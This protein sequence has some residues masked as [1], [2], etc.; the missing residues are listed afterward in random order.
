[1]LDLM[2]P[3]HMIQ[4]RSKSKGALYMVHNLILG[5][6]IVLR[7]WNLLLR[8]KSQ[9]RTSGITKYNNEYLFILNF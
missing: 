5:L 4:C 8:W 6:I 3:S 9:L 1:M 7:K 2:S